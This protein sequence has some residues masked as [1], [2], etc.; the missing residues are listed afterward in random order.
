M[1]M[2]CRA[3]VKEAAGAPFEWKK[4]IGGPLQRKR[5]P[6]APKRT[7]DRLQKKAL[8]RSKGLHFIS[9]KGLLKGSLMSIFLRNRPQMPLCR[10]SGFINICLQKGLFP[11]KFTAYILYDY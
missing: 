1:R 4:N 9:K 5:A 8:F 10:D 6:V 3:T 7:R 11:K 2:F